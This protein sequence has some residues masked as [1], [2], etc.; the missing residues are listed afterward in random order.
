[1]DW[2]LY[3][4]T[5]PKTRIQWIESLEV[6]A[7]MMDIHETIEALYQ[8]WVP[9][10]DSS[11]LQYILKLKMLF[12]IHGIAMVESQPSPLEIINGAYLFSLPIQSYRFI[13]TKDDHLLK[14]I[15]A[16]TTMNKL[17][18]Y[19]PTVTRFF[20]NKQDRVDIEHRLRLIYNIY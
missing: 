9:F 18:P 3:H 10:K 16:W 12:E 14:L 1:M 5:Q 4:I 8:K 19:Q 2:E 13:N 20:P 6:R 15:H 17:F 11:V 7:C